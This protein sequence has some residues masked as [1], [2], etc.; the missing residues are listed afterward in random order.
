MHRSPLILWGVRLPVVAMDRNMES[1]GDDEIHPTDGQKKSGTRDNWKQLE[2]MN[3]NVMESR[4]DSRYTVKNT[5]NF[6]S[7]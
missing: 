7:V 4:C 2:K 3:E 5:F 6:E 1:R